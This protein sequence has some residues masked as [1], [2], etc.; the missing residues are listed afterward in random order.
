MEIFNYEF[1]YVGEEGIFIRD[2]GQIWTEK[3]F[4]YNYGKISRK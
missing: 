4:S 3:F 2:D 1:Y